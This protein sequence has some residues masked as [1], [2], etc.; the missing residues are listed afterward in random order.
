MR[1]LRGVAERDDIHIVADN[2]DHL[3][4]EIPKKWIKINPSRIL[5]EEEKERKREQALK[6]LRSP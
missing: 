1:R 6:N 4:C 2:G 5:S 3:I